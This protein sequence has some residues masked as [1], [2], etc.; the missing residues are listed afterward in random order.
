MYKVCFYCPLVVVIQKT[1]LRF[2]VFFFYMF[3]FEM[4]GNLINILEMLLVTHI[5]L[6]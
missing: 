1:L 5:S 3:I 4:L 2:L 6:S